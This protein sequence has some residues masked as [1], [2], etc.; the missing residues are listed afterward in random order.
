LSLVANLVRQLQGTFEIR[1]NHGSEIRI[2]F[3]DAL[4][5][6]EVSA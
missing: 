4:R 1:T 5:P 3:P 6:V 2:E